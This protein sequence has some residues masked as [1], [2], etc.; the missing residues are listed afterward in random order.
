MEP[1]FVVLY[2]T[3]LV[4][5]TTALWWFVFPEWPELAVQDG[6]LAGAVASVLTGVFGR[7]T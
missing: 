5:G 1:K 7:M 6:L 2:G 3:A 4:I